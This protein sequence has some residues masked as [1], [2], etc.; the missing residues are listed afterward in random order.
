MDDGGWKIIYKN[1][2]YSVDDC[3]DYLT[4]YEN[5]KHTASF[6]TKEKAIEYAMTMDYLAKARK[7]MI[8]DLSYNGC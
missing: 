3:G 5:H 2:N 1:D 6:K 4:V 7:Q 8:K